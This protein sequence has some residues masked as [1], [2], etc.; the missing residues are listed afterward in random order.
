[1]N[2]PKCGV[3]LKRVEVERSS[4]DQCPSCTGVWLDAREMSGVLDLPSKSLSKVYGTAKPGVD[5]KTGTCP[6]CEDDTALIKLPNPAVPDI[7]TDSCPNCYGV[8]LDGGELGRIK[9]KY[10]E[11]EDLSV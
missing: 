7:M 11:G 4:V 3:G 8:W 1:M 10:G 9:A 2:C 5:K 6:R